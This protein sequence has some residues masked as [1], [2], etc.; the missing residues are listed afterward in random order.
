[1]PA[2]TFV[3]KNIWVAAG[4]GDL[5]RVRVSRTHIFHFYFRSVVTQELIEHQCKSSCV[6]TPLLLIFI[7]IRSNVPQY[8]RFIYI[9]PYVRFYPSILGSF[10]LIL[11]IRHAAASYGHLDTLTY[12]ISRGRLVMV[13]VSFL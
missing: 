13:H 6:N 1:M 12:L 9:H 8:T 5:G 4:D 11:C 3:D 2:S 7:N 10:I